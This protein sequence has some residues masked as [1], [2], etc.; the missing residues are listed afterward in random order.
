MLKKLIPACT[1]LIIALS[2]VTASAS[3]ALER[4]ITND[5][6]QFDGQVGVFAKNLK[7]E[8]TIKYNQDTV[9]PT[10][11]TS[12]LIVA[13]ATY[14][15]LYP[16]APSYKQNEYDQD[17]DMM[18]KVSDN[19]TFEALLNEFDATKKDGFDKV[20]RDLRLSKTEIHDEQAFK[21]YSYHSVT[22]PYE[23][24]K[25][26][27]SIYKEKYIDKEHVQRLKDDL[28][29]TIFHDEIPRY[30]Q[31]P[32]FHKVGELDDVLCDVGVV[33][34]GHDPILISFYTRTGD[35]SYSSDFI[36]TVSAK[37]YNALRR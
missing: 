33:Q 23:M 30:M 27:E 9:F 5:L 2:V 13:L 29:N 17:I 21:K 22:T 7:T 4:E 16:K 18:I 10:A 3:T 31:V 11:S 19:N 1:A 28:A 6:K 37:L 32:V 34:D 35:H 36:A 12:K 14:K 26:L 24:S 8:K 20:Q 15:Y 25:V